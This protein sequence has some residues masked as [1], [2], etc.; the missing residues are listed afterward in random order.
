MIP[1]SQGTY[2]TSHWGSLPSSGSEAD[3][4]SPWPEDIESSYAAVP[5]GNNSTIDQYLDDDANDSWFQ[6]EVFAVHADT[7]GTAD[8]KPGK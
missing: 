2:P 3:G 6:A 4:L 5:T 7:F 1:N 8:L